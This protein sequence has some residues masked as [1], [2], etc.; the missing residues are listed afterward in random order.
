MTQR[1]SLNFVNLDSFEARK[2]DQNVE[3]ASFEQTDQSWPS[4]E[5]V[6]PRSKAT[7]QLAMRVPKEDIMLFNQL[8]AEGKFSKPQLLRRM[9]KAYQNHRNKE[10]PGC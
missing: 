1:K 10:N 3:P 4:R 5:P 7:E 2:R 6:Q 8:A 9:M